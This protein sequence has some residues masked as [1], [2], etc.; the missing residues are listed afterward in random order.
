MSRRIERVSLDQPNHSVRYTPLISRSAPQTAATVTTADWTQRFGRRST[1]LRRH[2]PAFP[3]HLVVARQTSGTTGPYTPVGGHSR[4]D[5]GWRADRATPLRREDLWIGGNGPPILDAE[6][7]EHLCTICL[8]LKSHPVSY[9]C[10]HG[11][12]YACIRLWLEVEWGCPDCRT[13]M[14]APPFRVFSE[15]KSIERLHGEWDTS[16]VSY[17]WDGIAFP[18]LVM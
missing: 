14:T 18:S 1:F 12:C 15:E 11:H 13:V 6:Y 2:I 16:R 7:T 9:I 3:A 4:S 8:S 10:G 17:R 5:N